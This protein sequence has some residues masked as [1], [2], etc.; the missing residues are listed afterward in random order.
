M[1][2]DFIPKASITSPKLTILLWKEYRSYWDN[3]LFTILS[4]HVLLKCC[5]RISVFISMNE[6]GKANSYRMV[7]H[8]SCE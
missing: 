6:K 4:M 2:I 8:L 7:L 5:N 1:N 3:L